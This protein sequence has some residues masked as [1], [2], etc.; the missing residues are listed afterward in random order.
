MPSP[1]D[2]SRTAKKTAAQLLDLDF[3]ENRAR[4][5]DIAAFLDRLDRASD[6]PD[7]AAAD[8]RARELR[9]ALA[10]LLEDGPDRAA[11]VLDALS[12][13]T[14]EPIDTAPG[15]GATGA[16]PGREGG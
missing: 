7:A 12:D 2:P 1:P 16:W 9:K 10:I 4:A 11:R 14:D 15:K 3:L 5:I 6:G 8:F 13:P